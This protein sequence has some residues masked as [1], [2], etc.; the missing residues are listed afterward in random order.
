MG[1]GLRVDSLKPRHNSSASHFSSHT[2][3]LVALFQTLSH[4]HRGTRRA[5]LLSV[6]DLLSSVT[7]VR[8]SDLLFFLLDQRNICDEYD[9]GT[10][11]PHGGGRV[12]EYS[13]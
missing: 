7:H 3:E 11:A 12:E 1:F 10:D 13:C 5:L 9:L 4:S 8:A 6:R 2:P